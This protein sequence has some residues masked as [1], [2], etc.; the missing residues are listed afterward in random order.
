MN[1]EFFK[2]FIR[3]YVGGGQLNDKVKGAAI[4]NIASVKELKTIPIPLPSIQEHS[5]V[6]TYLDSVYEHTSALEAETQERLDQL[7]TLKSSLLDTAFRG[8]L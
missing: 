6:V 1:V 8:Q 2:Y 5:Q 7:T 3:N 4:K